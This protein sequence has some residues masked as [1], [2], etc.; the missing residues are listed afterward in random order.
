MTAF[1]LKDELQDDLRYSR[2]YSRQ[3]HLAFPEYERLAANLPSPD[4]PEHYTKVTDGTYA[5]LLYEGAMRTW[6]KLQTGRAVP[7]PTDGQ[8]FEEWK[9][10]TVNVLWHNR[11]I[12]NANTQAKFFKKL[13][14]AEHRRRI[15]GSCPLYI[16]T[17]SNES[18]TG[19]DFTIGNPR[20]V[21]LPN[22]YVTS[23]DSPRV[24]KLSHYDKVQ[25]RCLIEAAEQI[26]G[27]DGWDIPKL[28][29]IL[30]SNAFTPKTD[31]LSYQES[32]QAVR[33]E[34][35]TFATCYQRGYGAPC[36]TLYENGDSSDNLVRE[37]KN[38]LH[39]GDIPVLVYYYL[40]D[41]FNPY[42]VSAAEL[43]GPS[44]NM[45]DL[46]TSGH[47][48]AVMQL[49]D[50]AIQVAGD[51]NNDENADLDTFSMAPGNLA[52]TGSLEVSPFAP[53]KQ[54]V[55]SFP[56]SI[57]TYKTNVMNGVGVSDAT[58]SAS[59]SGNSQYSKTPAGVSLQQERTGIR[60]NSDRQDAD[61]IFVDLARIMINMTVQR[62]SGSD[63]INIT[64]EQREKL[65]NAG[66]DIPED[67]K[68]IIAEFD[69]LRDG[70]FE[71][72]VDPGSSELDNDDATKQAINDA[73]TVTQE[74]PDIDARLA[75][76]GKKLNMGMLLY[77][78]YEKAGIDNVDKIIVEL[79]DEEKMAMQQQQEQQAA[80][81]DSSAQ[82][83]PDG[84][85]QGAPQGV[86]AAQ[87]G[88]VD[89]SSDDLVVARL[90]AEG[91]S[92]QDIQDFLDRQRSV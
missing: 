41:L 59:A 48:V 4:L 72:D 33:P 38:E 92:D 39:F 2:E 31:N 46:M 21:Y 45:V 68:K 6:Q 74:I 29:E 49:I 9:T 71:F 85:M 8:D 78:Y 42:G 15:Y 70:L 56:S 17:I 61:D 37:E 27:N 40:Q 91:W 5:S 3:F 88:G 20:D 22:G 18:Y 57:G 1:L 66:A 10:E 30:E 50:P 89:T 16:F 82:Q 14:I 81:T 83:A 26:E 55:E 13:R 53:D 63:V 84:Q 52:F 65:I 64:K 77:E 79:S 23:L 60:E 87:G 58:V 76:E 24:W 28:K 25:L 90:R 34:R 44:Q 47:S 80:A 69:E 75:Q 73:I 11:I 62:T 86:D 32:S 51:V 54:T 35:V 43:S 12:K 67:A 36:Y 19:A 7:M